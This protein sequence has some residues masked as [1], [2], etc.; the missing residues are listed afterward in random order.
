M[1]QKNKKFKLLTVVGARPQFIKAAPLSKAIAQNPYLEE[2][3]GAY[4]ATLRLPTLT[5]FF[6]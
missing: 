5:S 2:A 4:W 6:R 3:P 1:L